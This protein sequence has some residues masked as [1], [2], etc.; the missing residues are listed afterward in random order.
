MESNE[1]KRGAPRHYVGSADL[2]CQA[3]RTPKVQVSLRHLP[4]VLRIKVRFKKSVWHRIGQGEG[5]RSCRCNTVDEL[6]QG[7]VTHQRDGAALA[8][9]KVVQTEDAAV[10]SEPEFMRQ[11]RPGEVV[12]DE[13]ARSALS[14][15]PRI[16]EPSQCGEG[17]IGAACL[18]RTMG[19]AASVF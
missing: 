5:F 17:R 10:G 16:V 4:G 3:S 13:E 18:W 14:L 19:N 15:H 6:R 11:D 8:E 7:C 2:N 9:I 12:I 1:P